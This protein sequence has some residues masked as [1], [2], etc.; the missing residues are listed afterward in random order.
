MTPSPAYAPI[1]VAEEISAILEGRLPTSKRLG[2]AISKLK[3]STFVD[4]CALYRVCR[5]TGD[6]FLEGTEGLSKDRI[7]ARALKAGDGLTGLV[8]SS[9]RPLAVRDGPSHPNFRFLPGLMEE[10]YHSY[11][12]VPI[13]SGRRVIGALIVQTIEPR[14]FSREDIALMNTIAGQMAPAAASYFRQRDRKTAD[15][16]LDTPMPDG[17]RIVRGRSLA[18]GCFLGAPQPLLQGLQLET[19]FTPPSRGAKAEIEAIRDA[20]IK[21]MEDLE[22]EAKAI[23]GSEGYQVLMAHR[24]VLED[25]ELRREVIE[26]IRQNHSAGEAVRLT[27]L[28]WIRIL[29]DQPDPNFAGRAADFRDIGNRLLRALGIQEFQ[30]AWGAD[31]A[32]VLARTILPGDLLRLGPER[33]G[34]MIITDQAVHSHTSILARSFGIPAVQVDAAYMDDMMKAKCLFVDGGD[35]AVLLDPSPEVA[36]QFRDRA[37]KVDLLPEGGPTDLGGP[38]ETRD[39]FRIRIGLNAGLSDELGRIDWRQPDDIGLYR[40]EIPFLSHEKLPDLAAQ[41]DHYSQVLE[42]AAGRNVAFRTFDFGGDKIPLALNFEREDNPM[43]GAR[44]TRYMLAHPEMFR[45]QLKA[46]LTVSSR[47]P[48]SILLPMIATAEELNLALDEINSVKNEL[49]QTGVEFDAEAPIGIMLEVPSVLFILDELSRL[50]DFFC[51]G[52]NDLIQY[53]M[54]ADRSNPR[55]AHFYNWHHPA[56]LSALDHI[57]RSAK[58]HDRPITMCGEIANHPWA[59]LVLVGMGYDH[60]SV[61]YHSIPLIKWTLLQT[62]SEMLRRLATDAMKATSSTGVIELFYGALEELRREAPPLAEILAT[63][64]ERLRSNSFW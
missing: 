35:G 54:A 32:V 40:T 51:V 39:G 41:I 29:G 64:L 59:A 49:D 20:V 48:M 57:L 1:L 13:Q 31:Q 58:R 53:L 28:R 44:S 23:S 6:L 55:V 38:V 50:A 60:L 42:K 46:L 61:D 47:G 21:V 26:K 17:A 45:T 10:V 2:K 24:I 52:S 3:E 14:D 37:Q 34:A 15:F 43:M 19:V 12:G 7:G 22:S 30:P 11:L 63:S 56:V 5:K 16:A 4:A 27:S 33:F 25:S 62:S 9:Q 36:E 8:V 18:P